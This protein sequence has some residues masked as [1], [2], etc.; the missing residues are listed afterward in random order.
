MSDNGR[1]REPK[2]KRGGGRRRA[3]RGDT[4]PVRS[5]VACRSP[6]PKDDVIRF[7]RTPD[8]GLAADISGKLPGRGAYT[9]AQR[10]CLEKAIDRGAF[11]R[12]FEAPVLAEL[13]ELIEEVMRA[14]TARCLQTLG[15]A[16]RMGVAKVG[17]TEALESKERNPSTKIFVAEDLS[18]RSLRVVGELEE[19]LLLPEKAAVGHALGRRA[20]GVVG[21]APCA[22][23]DGLQRTCRLRTSL[24]ELG[25]RTQ[26]LPRMSSTQEHPQDNDLK[27]E[28]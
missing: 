4:S 23:A 27:S 5:C 3:A 11:K 10:S 25:L 28:S 13:E 17:R 2:R 19:I 24:G 12:A 16:R 26:T 7:V 8:G 15:L 9:C 1:K 14:L 6:A 18:A 22:I 21:I 20:T